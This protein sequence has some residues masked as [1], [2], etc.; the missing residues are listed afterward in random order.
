MIN[1]FI[2]KI[3]TNLDGVLQMTNMFDGIMMTGDDNANQIIVELYHGHTKYSIPSGTKIVGYF[4]RSDGATLEVDG[5]ITEDGCASV[6]IPALAY[7]VAG[8]MTIAVRMFLDP[9]EETQRGYYKTTLGDFVIVE[10]DT[11]TE[12]PN[13]EEIII[14]EVTEN[15]IRHGYYTSDPVAFII[16]PD[17]QTEGPDGEPIIEITIPHTREE[18]GYYAF[19]TSEF[20]LVDDP[21][22]TEGPNGEEIITRTITVYANKVGIA[23]ASCF[24]QMTETDTIIEPGHI[25]PD[26]N[27]VVAKLAEIDLRESAIEIV[28]IS[29]V[30]AETARDSAEAARVIAENA[31]VNAEASRVAAENARASTESSRASNESSRIASENARNS[32]E[33]ARVT[34]ENA[35]VN[36]EAARV[37]SDA[38]RNAA[39][40]NMSISAVG[41]NYNDTPTAT[42][43]D[44]DGH[45]HISLGLIPGQPFVIKKSFNSVSQME[46]Y[47]GTDV[48]VNDF[49]IITATVED[50]D[51]AKLYMKTSSGWFFVTDLSGATGIQ[52]PVGPTGN[53]IANAVVN[54]N[55]ELVL[56]FTNGTTYTSGSIR[57]AQGLTGPTGNGISST[58]LNN[59]YTLTLGYTNG[60]SWTSPNS[61]R[62]EKGDKGDKGDPGVGSTM[63]SYD[64]TNNYLTVTF[65]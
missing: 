53:G 4:I 39:I 18:R 37:A 36:A 59:D 29:R 65:G 9:G 15:E 10:D 30:T 22:I 57:G 62:G 63:L 13:G 38:A 3:R 42:I 58:T 45:K 61:I 55:Y 54:N 48:K 32:A 27:D 49:V 16:V 1:N 20:I 23:S 24:V 7:Q 17:S 28:E 8:N 47:T 11:I 34:A 41:L 5:E 43:S 33:A 6:I 44:V 60:T 50:P 46:S 40:Q 52:G 56:T 35:R 25:I 51:N 26:V 12:G 14:R 64:S 2:T 19:N 31:R 21:S